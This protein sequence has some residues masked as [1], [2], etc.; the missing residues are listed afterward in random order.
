MISELEL[1]SKLS[2]IDELDLP[3]FLH[4]E[5]CVPFVYTILLKKGRLD[6]FQDMIGE[7]FIALT[8]KALPVL[9]KS[10]TNIKGYIYTCVRNHLINLI[11]KENKEPTNGA[12]ELPEKWS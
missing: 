3:L 4:E 1:R 11:L 5:L 7:A 8:Q 6:L 2:S 12:V 9:D 10:R